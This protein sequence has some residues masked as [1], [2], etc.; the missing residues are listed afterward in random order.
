MPFKPLCLLVALVLAAVSGCSSY[1]EAGGDDPDAALEQRAQLTIDTFC[2]TDPSLTKFFDSAAGYAVFPAV[3]KGAV[4]VGAAAGRGVVYQG[5][6]VIGYADLRQATVGVQ[7]GGQQYS[8][9][10]FFQTDADLARFKADEIEFAAQASAV[11]SSDSAAANADYASGVA[12]FVVGQEGLMFEASVGG[13][14][15]RYRPKQ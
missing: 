13:Q 6:E 3:T 9:L 10:I 5:G 12:I 8:E 15:F 11:A 7:L 4:G 2:K 1:K 14:K